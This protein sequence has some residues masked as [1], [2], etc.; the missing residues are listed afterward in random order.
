MSEENAQLNNDVFK[1]SYE[2][3]QVWYQSQ[4]SSPITVLF[5]PSHFK[6]EQ[7][8]IQPKRIKIT[9]E[10]VEVEE[11]NEKCLYCWHAF[12]GAT[13]PHG[14]A[15]SSAFNPPKGACTATVDDG[16]RTCNC[17]GRTQWLSFYAD[18]R[19]AAEEWASRAAKAGYQAYGFDSGL[20]TVQSVDAS[21][22]KTGTWLACVFS[23]TLPP[24]SSREEF[25]QRI[26][27]V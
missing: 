8:F 23:E 1:K 3:A 15:V 12:H 24:V 13:E 21:G 10:L 2:L 27:I 18:S 5:N 16:N 22:E 26:G 7:S 11:N 4:A 20:F 25:N 6:G 9:I 14:F 19:E 17:D